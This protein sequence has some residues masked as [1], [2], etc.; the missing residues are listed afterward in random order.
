MEIEKFIENFG[1]QFDDT[2]ASE[3]DGKTIFK[4]L[5]EWGSLSIL[6]I[7]AMCDE[8][9]NVPV[10]GEEIKNA[11]TVENLFNVVMNKKQ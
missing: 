9:Y 4:D 11:I 5:D 6:M 1:D 8:E 2:D 3:I 10:T 7:I